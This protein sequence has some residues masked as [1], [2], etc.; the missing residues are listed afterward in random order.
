MENYISSYKQ[1]KYFGCGLKTI[2]FADRTQEFTDHLENNCVIRLTLKYFHF[3][4]LN[5]Q[6]T[7]KLNFL[8]NI[9]T[10]LGVAR[11]ARIYNLQTRSEKFA[12]HLKIVTV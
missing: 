11:I 1:L 8:I 6:K 3:I 2:E 4:L 10:F 9:E 5:I 12:D 7:T